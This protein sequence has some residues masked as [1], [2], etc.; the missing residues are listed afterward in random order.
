MGNF[1]HMSTVFKFVRKTSSDDSWLS[2]SATVILP[3]L[4]GLYCRILCYA[5]PSKS[6]GGPGKTNITI[7]PFIR[8]QMQVLNTLSSIFELVIDYCDVT[9]PDAEKTFF[10]FVKFAAA[11]L[12]GSDFQKLQPA[13][14]DT[15]YA[16]DQLARCASSALSNLILSFPKLF[17]KAFNL[18]KKRI[19]ALLDILHSSPE[20]STQRS[21]LLILR[22][23][24]GEIHHQNADETLR[25]EIED[26]LSKERFSNGA[27]L[28]MFQS[29]D[30]DNDDVMDKGDVILAAMFESNGLDSRCF[31]FDCS[32]RMKGKINGR[33]KKGGVQ[34][35]S[36]D[37]NR[38]S[39]TIHFKSQDPAYFPLHAL[40]SV[41][42]TIK[43]KEVKFSFTPEEDSSERELIIE[44]QPEDKALI[45]KAIDHRTSLIKR[46]INGLQHS[47]RN[48]QIPFQKRKVSD[49]E[50]FYRTG[51]GEN[52]NEAKTQRNKDLEEK[53][54]SRVT[55]KE[56]QVDKHVE[57]VQASILDALGAN[58]VNLGCQDLKGKKKEKEGL[59]GDN[60]EDKKR[61]IFSQMEG[62]GRL[63]QGGT[64]DLE[65]ES[66]TSSQTES[67][68]SVE[69][70]ALA[71]SNSNASSPNC[72]ESTNC[73]SLKKG[74]QRVGEKEK[75]NEK[76]ATN[77][78]NKDEALMNESSSLGIHQMSDLQIE[79]SNE[80][81]DDE[82]HTPSGKDS[83]SGS[84][85]EVPEDYME[86]SSGD[87]VEERTKT[88]TEGTHDE[89]VMKEGGK[90]QTKIGSAD[91]Y[92]EEDSQGGSS[93]SFDT[94]DNEIRLKLSHSI[95]EL[96]KVSAHTSTLFKACEVHPADI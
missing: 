66:D 39:A 88:H 22:K 31:T 17:D 80:E 3:Q 53:D 33:L 76:N 42:W 50:P 84:D 47:F 59:K 9:F 20:L 1:H 23:L 70:L 27:A 77:S 49:T 10:T 54:K 13:F 72:S 71:E 60:N 48:Q 11:V 64:Q 90:T 91:E 28:K 7:T 57:D 82:N 35:V 38:T 5:D 95:G 68:F 78:K 93:M 85:Y 40:L 96:I 8:E 94:D 36:A 87:E 32:I 44:L 69:N 46:K 26:G 52:L 45:S 15:S 58:S 24:Y 92:S 25:Q 51:P 30:V 81:S 61:T 43:Q 37:W 21:L 63:L 65:E 16:M 4:S 89:K 12:F 29:F 75:V 19:G 41:T 2:S 79:Q 83:S 34:K 55:G 56:M 18:L 6:S 62:D 73:P 67:S 86:M 74:P 14:T